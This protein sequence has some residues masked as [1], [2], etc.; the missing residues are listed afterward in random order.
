L[1]FAE[2]SRSFAEFAAP[3]ETTTTSPWM[4]SSPPS[5]ETTTSVTSV[6][7]PFVPSSTASA[8][9]RS[10]TLGCSSAGRTPST[11]ASD[12]ACTRHGK[13]SHS[14]QRMHVLNAGFA[15][16]TMIPHGAWNGR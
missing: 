9:V 11:S 14:A 6:P 15:S 16:S 2:R 7:S 3:H 4:C 12:F 1:S 13:P 10:V 8:F 5:W